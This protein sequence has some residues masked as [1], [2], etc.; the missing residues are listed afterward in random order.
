MTTAFDSC[1]STMTKLKVWVKANIN[2]RQYLK[3]SSDFRR[4]EDVDRRRA[5]LEDRTQAATRIVEQHLGSNLE[6]T[7][8][9]RQLSDVT[10]AGA[11]AVFCSAIREVLQGIQENER[12]RYLHPT[13]AHKLTLVGA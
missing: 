2:T 12:A 11:K 4:L 3:K 13:N 10:G 7:E 1:T 5:E 6:F 8:L 9:M